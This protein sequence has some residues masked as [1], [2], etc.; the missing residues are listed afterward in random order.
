MYWS[1]Q[2]LFLL[3]A[4]TA[5]IAPAQQSGLHASKPNIILI[6]A[7]DLSYRDLSI[8]GQH[9]FR[10]PTLDQLALDGTSRRPIG[11]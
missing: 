6:L 11:R 3:L 1:L 10:T 9:Q 2:N 8:R 4:S 7:D 5:V